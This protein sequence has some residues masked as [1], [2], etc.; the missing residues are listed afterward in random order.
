MFN[1]RKDL[2]F[3]LLSQIG[4]MVIGLLINKVLSNYLSTDDFATFNIIKRNASVVGFTLLG[5]L[6]IALPRFLPQLEKREE[7]RDFIINSLWLMFFITIL[8]VVIFILFQ[9]YLTELIFGSAANY[10]LFLM[11]LNGLAIA[12]T[13]YLYALYRGVHELL[14]FSLVQFLIQFSILLFCVF[15]REDFISFL[16]YSSLFQ[17]VIVV[18]LL[19]LYFKKK[20]SS[21]ERY[22]YNKEEV[23][24][25]FRYSGP[26]LIGDFIL[27][28]LSSIPLIILSRRF[29]LTNSSYFV[30]AVTLNAIITPIFSYVG[31]ILLPKVSQ[32][33]KDKKFNRMKSLLNKFMLL[34]LL[35]SI[36]TIG[37]IYLLGENLIMILF[38]EKYLASLLLVKVTALSIIP[39]SVYLLLRNP[40]DAI[41]EKAYNTWNLLIT[42]IFVCIGMSI[43]DTVLNASIIYVIG[44]GIL[45]LL[46]FFRWEQLKRS[47]I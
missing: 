39:N 42:L 23:Y 8:I 15:Y 37:F 20:L 17:C 19:S 44:F 13:S 21:Y 46:S 38:S 32:S 36:C 2:I 28:S 11:L 12:L 14:K 45:A 43:A 29:G 27:F 30:V 22:K 1:L 6:G 25:I 35:M 10:L 5:G 7:K 41:S 3:T 18:L 4:I 33:I 47:V 40:I 16:I 9:H 24:S 31:V 26:R 34:Y